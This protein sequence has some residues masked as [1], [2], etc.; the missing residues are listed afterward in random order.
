MRVG[1][2]SSPASARSWRAG[3]STTTTL[4]ASVSDSRR[5]TRVA[6]G[7]DL[8]GRERAAAVGVL[9]R[10]A[11]DVGVGQHDRRRERAGV[12]QRGLGVTLGRRRERRAGCEPRPREDRGRGDPV[13]AL[14]DERA[15]PRARPGVEVEEPCDALLLAIDER[16]AVAARLAVAVVLKTLGERAAHRPVELEIDPVA[17]LE[18]DHRAQRRV[19][20]RRRADERHGAD[21]VLLALVHVPG[22]RDALAV[23]AVGELGLVALAVEVPHLLHER[24]DA[25]A[26]LGE[27]ERVVRALRKH[28]GLLAQAEQLEQRLVVDRQDLAGAGLDLHRADRDVG[29]P[30]DRREL[31][32]GARG[33]RD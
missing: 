5:G 29:V 12:E 4:T 16:A 31:G 7:V 8:L 11:L 30:G 2:P 15:D 20:L 1:S 32:L 14:D 33:H 23:G 25:A 17:G 9:G 24:H 28:R 10:T 27:P 3:A 6:V 18:R 26:V 21:R 19:V 22:H 13:V